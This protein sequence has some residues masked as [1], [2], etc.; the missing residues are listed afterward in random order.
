MIRAH[1]T[2]M[3]QFEEKVKI[4]FCMYIGKITELSRVERYS[5]SFLIYNCRGSV[6]DSQGAIHRDLLY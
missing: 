3:S 1:C 5:A 4:R 6:L 2:R